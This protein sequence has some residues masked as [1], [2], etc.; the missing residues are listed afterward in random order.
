[1]TEP[2]VLVVVPTR[3][4]ADFASAAARSVL[5]AGVENVSVVVSD[6]STEPSQVAELSG[7]CER[8]NDPRLS[9][10]RPP[11]SMSMTDHWNWAMT[12]V[13]T[14][15]GM[16][17]VTFLSDRMVFLPE[18]LAA[19]LGVV[20]SHR[21]D[22]VSFN[23]DSI[24]DHTFPVQLI[25][26]PWSGKT[27][28][29]SSQQL[30]D[31]AADA[32]LTHHR[33]TPRILNSIVPVAVLERIRHRFGKVFGSLAPD[34]CFAY[35]CLS[36]MDTF[37][38]YDRPCIVEYGVYRSNGWSVLLCRPTPDAKDFVRLAES[39]G[40]VNWAAPVP[41]LRT[42]SNAIFHEYCFVRQEVG[43]GPMKPMDVESCLE[44]LANEVAHLEDPEVRAEGFATLRRH[45]WTG[46]VPNMQVVPRVVEEL[47]RGPR[48]VVLRSIS[49][50]RSRVLAHPRAKPVWM[51]LGHW[52]LTPSVELRS[53]FAS[54]EEAL[55]HCRR[56]PRSPSRH[57][58]H[59]GPL[60]PQ[61]ARESTQP[62]LAATTAGLPTRHP[63]T[64]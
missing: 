7:F 62:A 37:V 12:E 53:S 40:G 34:Y 52:G 59:L 30:L 15:G 17:H 45:G 28:T 48:H 14:R 6:N 29:V 18:A 57:L 23:H 20:T 13:L 22:V 41:G 43:G 42:G 38:Y 24:D 51:T 9:Y 2:V 47:R 11:E 31:L 35:R 58:A 44:V 49:V 33:P 21:E 56:R 60:A 5:S 1:M 3:N 39:Q 26:N 8:L 19:L 61:T 54:V 25:Q 50:F 63:G 10:I 55:D 4:R 36:L 16:T 27:I 64:P 32:D 46:R